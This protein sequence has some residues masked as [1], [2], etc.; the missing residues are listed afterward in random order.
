MKDFFPIILVLISIAAWFTHVIKCL[1]VGKYIL[2]LA[3]GII[4]PIGIIHGV[5]VWLGV[6]W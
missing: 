6:G 3:G 5:G 2:L 1:M 4:F